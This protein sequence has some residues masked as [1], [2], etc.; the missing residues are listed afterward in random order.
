MMMCFV[1]L[2][3]LGL[4]A[5]LMQLQLSLNTLQWNVGDELQ[6][7]KIAPTSTIKFI[8]GMVSCIACDSVMY[9]DSV[10][11]SAISI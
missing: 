5:I 1:L 7:G 4:S 11:L 10:I 8:K 3:H 2:V 6:S 9:L